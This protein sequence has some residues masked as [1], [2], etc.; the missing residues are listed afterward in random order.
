MLDFQGAKGIII[1]GETELEAKVK[2]LKNFKAAEKDE[3]TG[4]IIK[5]ESELNGYGNCVIEGAVGEEEIFEK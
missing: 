4:D 3:I 2:K 5:R 1:S